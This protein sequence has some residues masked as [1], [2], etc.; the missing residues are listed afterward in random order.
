ML[1]PQLHAPGLGE[2]DHAPG[3]AG[4]AEAAVEQVGAVRR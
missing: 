4:V 1:H 3:H 2:R